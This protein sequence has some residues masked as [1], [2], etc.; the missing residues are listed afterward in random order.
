MEFVD[1]VIEETPALDPERIGVTGGSYGGW[2]TNWIIGHTNRFKA[3]AS[4]R[5]FSNW[6]SDFSASEIGPMFDVS[7]IGATPWEEPER[8]WWASPAAYVD[9]VETPTLFIHS[10]MDHNCPLSEAMQM[11]AAIKYCGI[12][13]R[14]CLFEGESHELSRSGKPRHRVR[15]IREI[16]EW[17]DRY[18]GNNQSKDE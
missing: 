14:M 16:T 3:A 6:L 12:P 9:K 10:L 4:Q 15:R 17:M 1:H 13:S 11:F 8:L 5:S 7:E 18:L 2:M